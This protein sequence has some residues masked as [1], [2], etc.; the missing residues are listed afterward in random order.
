[1]TMKIGYSKAVTVRK[2]VVLGV[3]V[4]LGYGLLDLVVTFFLNQPS[5]V[6]LLVKNGLQE[7]Q[8]VV[9]ATV[10]AALVRMLDNV[11]KQKGCRG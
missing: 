9:V 7:G 10:A 1:M 8:A 2:G 4:G 11:R 6:E 5:I 3:L